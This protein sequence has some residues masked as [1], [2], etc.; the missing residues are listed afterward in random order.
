MQVYLQDI[1]EEVKTFISGA[2]V[3]LQEGKFSQEASMSD[4]Q[5]EITRVLNHARKLMTKIVES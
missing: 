1:G 2:A 5:A 3:Y 4:S